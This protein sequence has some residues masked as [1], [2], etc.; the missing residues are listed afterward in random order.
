MAVKLK[1]E[2]RNVGNIAA[3]NIHPP[4]KLAVP[5]STFVPEGGV[6][7]YQAPPNMTLAP[8]DSRFITSKITLVNKEIDNAKEFVDKLNKDEGKG[9]TVLFPVNYDSEI[10]GGKKF[11][12]IEAFTV[13]KYSARIIK[14]EMK[15]FGEGDNHRNGK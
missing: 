4:D 12:L 8:G 1:F 2:L 11:R 6:L 3:V 9:I 7:K 14:S 10:N 5:K 13:R 15:I